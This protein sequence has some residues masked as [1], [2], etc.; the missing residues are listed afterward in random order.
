MSNVYGQ[1]IMASR[2]DPEVERKSRGCGEVV[3]YMLSPEELEKYRAMPPP[4]GKRRI[5]IR[6]KEEHELAKPTKYPH[7]TKEFL[8]AEFAAGKSGNQVQREQG[9]SPG[10]IQHFMKRF[11]IKSQHSPGFGNSEQSGEAV[12]N[13][14]LSADD[15]EQ[16]VNV[17]ELRLEIERLRHVLAEQIGTT[18]QGV[19]K[20][21]ELEKAL[22]EK[23]NDELTLN[24][25]QALASR[26][27][28][29]DWDMVSV[30]VLRDSQ[31]LPLMNFALGA[32]GEAGEIA[33]E[34][35]KVVYHGHDLN[36]DKLLKE[37]GDTLWYLSQLARVLQY[38]FG[39]AGKQNIEKLK[40]RYPE[41]FSE[42]L[43]RNRGVEG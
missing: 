24:G 40:E 7:I 9:M 18:N 23:Q 15:S 21:A 2:P 29:T 43:S 8:E 35:K 34:V 20:I 28:V 32:A 13:K 42:A 41:G 39:Y 16:Q 26:T 5:E 33:D 17:Q 3:P 22:K 19:E 30:R 38:R 6:T 31:L 27:A 10:T 1:R 12:L 37:I 4:T 25:Y 36:R 14:N 11:G